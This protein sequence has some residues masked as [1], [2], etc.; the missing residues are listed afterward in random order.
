MPNPLHNFSQKMLDKD[1]FLVT[2]PIILVET[3]Q[4]IILVQ[5][6]MLVE[7]LKSVNCKV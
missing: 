4:L 2:Q 3:Y 6:L 5:I 1:K 7:I